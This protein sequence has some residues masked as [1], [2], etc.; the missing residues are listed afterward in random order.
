M[1]IVIKHLKYQCLNYFFLKRYQMKTSFVK[2]NSPFL[3][4][5]YSLGEIDTNIKMIWELFEFK[6]LTIFIVL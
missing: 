3:K 5:D 4:L 1:L 2:F 6:E